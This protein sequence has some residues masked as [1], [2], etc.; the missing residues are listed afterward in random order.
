MKFSR[1]RLT[2]LVVLALV[3]CSPGGLF[4]GCGVACPF[5]AAMASQSGHR[6]CPQSATSSVRAASCC[7]T[8]QAAAPAETSRGIRPPAPVLLALAAPLALPSEPLAEPR[9]S[10]PPASPPPLHEGIGLYTL[11]AA[12]LI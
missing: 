9:A 6:C 3:A 10:G 12:F 11:H 4:A 5:M 8:V 1:I 7:E 2:A